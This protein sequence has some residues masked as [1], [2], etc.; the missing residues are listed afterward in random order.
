[1]DLSGRS[2]PCLQYYIRRCYGPCVSGPHHGRAFTPKPRATRKL[3][4]EGRR[5]ELIDEPARSRMLE[6][7]QSERFEQAAGLSRP[8][9][10]SFRRIEER[11]KSP[12]REGDDIDVLAWYAEP[13]QW[14]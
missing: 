10:H 8:V 5:H 7:S 13:P 11:K 14:R 1:M 6:A 3:F 4:L 12:P 9:A 2:S